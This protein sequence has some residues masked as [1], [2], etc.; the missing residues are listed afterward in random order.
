MTAVAVSAEREARKDRPDKRILSGLLQALVAGATA[1]TTIA[2]AV[3]AIQHA[4]GVLL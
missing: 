2:N 1:G 4:V 3:V